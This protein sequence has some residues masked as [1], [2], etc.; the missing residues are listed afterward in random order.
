MTIWVLS[1]EDAFLRQN[2]RQQIVSAQLTAMPE[3]MRAM[4]VT[5]LNNPNLQQLTDTLMSQVFALGGTPLLEVNGFDGFKAAISSDKAREAL[6]EALSATQKNVLFVVPKLDKKLKWVKWLLGQ[7]HVQHE[8]FDPLPFWEQEKAIARL[9]QLAKQH[10][11]TMQPQAAQHMVASLGMDF[12][13]LSQVMQ[14]AYT[15]AAGQLVTLAHVTPF[16]PSGD[17]LFDSLAQWIQQADAPQRWQALDHVLETDAPQ[18]VLAL[19][20]KMLHDYWLVK[21]LTDQGQTP[22]D[23]ASWV[24]KKPGWVSMQLRWLQR[25]PTQRLNDLKMKTL[26]TENALKSGQ[27]EARLALELLWAS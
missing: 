23:I 17:N 8:V 7:P 6:Q 4:M 15:L 3:A 21:T 26:Q 24:G 25:I 2:Q 10:H 18:R 9:M 1:G 13:A 20:Q 22:M 27:M 11:I 19:T 5:Q 12:Y 16:L 14:Q